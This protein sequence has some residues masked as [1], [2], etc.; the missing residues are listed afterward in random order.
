M[1]YYIII[2]N[3][4]HDFSIHVWYGMVWYDHFK[5]RVK[6]YGICID[7]N[8]NMIFLFSYIK[9]HLISI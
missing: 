4:V 8:Q 3:I 7:S 1:I 6:A 2:D 9:F 5:S